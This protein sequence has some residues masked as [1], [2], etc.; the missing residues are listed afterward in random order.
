MSKK[1]VEIEDLL[2]LIS[3]TDPKISP[4]GKR[5]VFVQTKMDE[6]ENTYHSHVHHISLET[7][8]SVP[9]TYGKNRNSQPAWSAD[10]RHIAF[11]SDRNDKNQVYLLSA[12]G[13][14][15]RAL[16]DFEKGVSSFRWSPCNKKIWVNALVQDG[17]T[18]TDQEAEQEDDKKKPEPYR[19]TGMK[20]KMDGTGLIEQ[21]YHRQIGSVDL[22]TGTVEQLT[23]GPYH[24]GLEAISHD[25]T[26]LVYGSA[27][28]ENQDFIFRQSL[29]MRDLETGEETSIIEQ[30]GYYG[31]AAFSFDDERLAF[32]GH[33]RAY[34]NATQADLYVYETTNETAQCL[35]E[36]IDAPIGDYVVAD[37]Q[38]GAQAP[39]V[40]WTQ[41][42]HLY[43][44]VSTEGDVRLYFASLDGA[45]YPAS[46]EDEHVYGYDIARDGSFALATISTPVSPGELFKLA[47]STGERKA[48]T[49]CN[50]KY[51]EQTELIAAEIVSHTTEDGF[52]VHGWLM[53]PR[54]FEAGKKHPLVV[55]IHGGPHAMYANTF[56]HEM[57]V[58]AA[59][60]YGVLY[61]NPRGSHGYGQSFVDA[62]RGDYGGG[63]Y[64]DI[65]G[66]LDNVLA[67]ND[68]V[69]TERLGVTGGSYGGF[70]TNWIVSHD[71]RF[72]AA[73][74][75]RSI[76]N[77]ISFFGVSD[78]GYYFSEW[79]HGAAMDNVDK[80][81]E[82]SPLKYTK[83]IN[84]P[85]LILHS[86]NDH[87]CPIEQA[88]QLF[89]TLK[90]MH[91]ETEFV[92][93]PEADHNLSRTGKPNLRFA[94]LQEIVGWMERL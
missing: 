67:E 78:I 32:V 71:D 33:S 3:V 60:G 75:Q 85:L 6:E 24:F 26:K 20:Y 87:R 86:E 59:N 4:D 49:S 76:C 9:W 29:Y 40:V 61:V 72:K 36:G 48:L 37:H 66:A 81:W 39:G 91:K 62:V 35:T 92:R 27:K 22:E 65:L 84:T 28:E 21:D 80:L 64:R 70:M 1:A 23:E 83:D 47:I 31:N 17:K 88:E 74:T 53:K 50:A 8:E 7:G 30:D 82:H 89:I 5:A 43:F 34:E 56:V 44:Q 12:S 15:A 54:G 90:S 14:E 57:Q 52:D 68:W 42:D 25:G 45:V 10:G 69:D 46:P 79:Q 13:G 93:F 73:V 19:T 2:E 94:R 51:L 55:N 38:Q 18:F 11:L 16:T 63:D 58:L 77:W 41:D